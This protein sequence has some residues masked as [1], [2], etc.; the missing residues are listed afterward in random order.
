MIFFLF[1]YVYKVWYKLYIYCEK[2]YN[3][4]KTETD[5]INRGNMWNTAGRH[6]V[7]IVSQTNLTYIEYAREIHG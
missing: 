3:T 6:L 5:N 2:L 1:F 4:V 7:D